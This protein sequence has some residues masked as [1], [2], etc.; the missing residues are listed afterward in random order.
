MTPSHRHPR[1][2]PI[3]PLNQPP[4]YPLRNWAEFGLVGFGLQRAGNLFDHGCPGETWDN[5]SNA[6]D[7]Q[8]I[9]HCPDWWVEVLSV[10]AIVL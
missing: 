8:L 4:N 3:L 9:K 10:D 7:I 1:Q 6:T 5:W 2:G